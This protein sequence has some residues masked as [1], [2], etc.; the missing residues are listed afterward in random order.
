MGGN[1][2]PSMF[3]SAGAHCCLTLCRQTF[4]GFFLFC[5]A[6]VAYREGRI[7]LAAGELIPAPPDALQAGHPGPAV[8][9]GSVI[10]PGL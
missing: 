8:S 1:E 4:K 2:K 5:P 9:H 7:A 3:S 6:G 10:S